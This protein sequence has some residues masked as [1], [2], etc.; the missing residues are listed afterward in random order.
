[1]N[2]NQF[3]NFIYKKKYAFSMAKRDKIDFVY[4]TSALEG[5]AMTFPEVQTLLE[6]TTVGGHKLSDE[7]QV[8]NQNRSIELL[9]KPV[10]VN[11]LKR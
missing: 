1:M 5:N 3:Q 10:I 4:N 9:L 2:Y 8:L 11:I 6:G 7:Q